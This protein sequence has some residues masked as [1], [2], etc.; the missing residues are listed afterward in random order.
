MVAG[1]EEEEFGSTSKAASPQKKK[2]KKDEGEGEGGAGEGEGEEESTEESESGGGFEFG[3]RGGGDEFM[4]V[5][6]YLGAIKPPTKTDPPSWENNPKPPE[7]KMEI[8]WIF[9]YNSGCG[10]SNLRYNINGDCMYHG[11]ALGIQLNVKKME[12]QFCKGHDDDISAFC[13][14]KDR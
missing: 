12:Q 6:P 7:C 11:A 1:E 13:I 10:G 2:T 4:A 9:G 5:K 14:S 3:E 8:E